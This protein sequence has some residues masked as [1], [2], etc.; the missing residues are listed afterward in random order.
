MEINIQE[1][2]KN[3]IK[4]VIGTQI[5]NEL[6]CKLKLEAE[7]DFMSISDLLRKIIYLYYKKQGVENINELIKLEIRKENE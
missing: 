5:S 7:N 1:N 2:S 3:T 4:K 6:Y